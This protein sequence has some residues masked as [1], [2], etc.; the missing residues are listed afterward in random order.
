[1]SA[2]ALDRLSA[3]SSRPVPSRALDGLRKLAGALASPLVPEDYLDLFDPLR[4]GADLRGRVVSVT[5]ETPDAVTT[6]IRPGKGWRGH[7]PGQYIRIGVDIDGVRHWRAYSLTSRTHPADGLIT[8]TTKAIP[9]GKVSNH[10]VAGLLTP[11]TLVHLDQATGDFTLPT[12]APARTLF[13]T[14][15]SGITPVMGM[16]RNRLG[17]L[18]D[19]VHLHISPTAAASLFL[20]ERQSYAVGSPSAASGPQAGPTAYR[21]LE[22]HDDTDGFTDLTRDLDALVPDWRERQAWGL[23][24]HR[25]ARCR[26]AALGHSR[27]HRGPPR[28]A[29]SARRSSRVARAGRSPSCAPT[30]RSDRRRHHADPRRRRGR[31]DPHAERL[32][33]GHLLRL[34]RHPA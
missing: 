19:V 14:A 10:L 33:D 15:G 7:V 34:R 11:G 21:L 26:R 28:R 25:P 23:R 27:A 1:V 4:S 20:T 9:E 5:H 12:P 29:R 24:P 32:P 13:I 31:R 30:S 6:T 8:I 18:A 22:R 2:P 3:S 17:D 16:L